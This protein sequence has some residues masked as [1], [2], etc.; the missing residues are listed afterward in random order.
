MYSRSLFVLCIVRRF[1][2]RC[3]FINDAYIERTIIQRVKRWWKINCNSK[4]KENSGCKE[5]YLK[6]FLCKI[7]ITKT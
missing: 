7:R 3:S 5:K 1:W 6:G 2:V 4:Y